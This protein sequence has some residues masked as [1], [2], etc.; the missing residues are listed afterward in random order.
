MLYGV[1]SWDVSFGGW[2]RG[3]VMLLVT[4]FSF[5]GVCVR[6]IIAG[7]SLDVACGGGVKV[8]GP[9]SSGAVRLVVSIIGWEV[10]ESGRF[11]VF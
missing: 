9:L 2:S 1:S 8:G 7:S 10:L 4:S 5:F 11:G 3:I 6:S